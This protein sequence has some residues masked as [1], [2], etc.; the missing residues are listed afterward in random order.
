MSSSRRYREALSREELNELLDREEERAKPAA[1]DGA[2]LEGILGL[3]FAAVGAG[4]AAGSW[5][6][7]AVVLGLGLYISGLVKLHRGER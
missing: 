6:V 5:Y 4:G 1:I 3:I 2:A 7:G